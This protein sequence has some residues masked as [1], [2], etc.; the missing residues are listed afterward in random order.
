M[1]A[2]APAFFA[3]ESRWDLCSEAQRWR[4]SYRGMG[5]GTFSIEV[6]PL[7]V[8]L[9]VRLFVLFRS[10]IKV[11]LL[12]EESFLCFNLSVVEAQVRPKT[13]GNASPILFVSLCFLLFSSLLF[14]FACL[15]SF[16]RFFAFFASWIRFLFLCSFAILLFFSLLVFLVFL[17]TRF[18]FHLLWQV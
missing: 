11:Q 13:T 18:P 14:R 5:R 10:V 8:C 17:G 6:I 2:S 3:A 4:N 15:P 16:R 12:C 7:C 9:F 1:R